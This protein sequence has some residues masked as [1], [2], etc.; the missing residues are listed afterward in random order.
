MRTSISGY[1]RIGKARELKF[2]TEAWLKGT[3]TEEGL[4]EVAREIRRESWKRIREA[5]IDLV[6]SNDFSL[7]DTTL[8]AAF[9]IGAIPERFA[10]A[11]LSPLERYF[12]MARGFQDTAR[13]ID[14]KALPMRKWFTTNYHYIV[15]EL[16]DESELIPSA[17]RIIS[18][19]NEARAL[20][21]D[22]R[23]TIIGPF[24]FLYL[25]SVSGARSRQDFSTEIADAYAK[26]L[27]LAGKEGIRAVEFDES[28]L[29]TDVSE[30]DLAAFSAIYDRIFAQKPGIDVILRSSFGDIRDAWDEVMA[31]PFSGIGLDFVDGKEGNLALLSERG[32]PTDRDLYAGIINGKNVWKLDDDY[33]RGLLGNIAH[34]AGIGPD[35]ERLIVAPSCS[36]LHVP[37]SASREDGL[38]PEVRARLSFAEEKCDE[39]I[40]L[41]KTYSESATSTGRAD[42][43]IINADNTIIRAGGGKGCTDDTHHR[44]LTVEQR[45]PSR[46]ER[47][48]VQR[49]AFSLPPLPT[50]TIG[51]FPQT[52]EVTSLR[53]KLRKG[54][55]ARSFYDAE[56]KRMVARAI[57]LQEEAGIDVLVHGEFERNDMVEFFGQSL[58]GFAFTAHGWVQS[59]GTRCVKPPIIVGDVRRSKPITVDLAAYAQSLTDKPVKGM[60]TGPV[61]ILNWSFPREDIPLSESA[62][63]IALAIREEVLD[64]EKAGIG[65]IQIDEAALKE[66]LPLRAKDRGPLYLDWAIPAFRLCSNGVRPETQIHTHMCYSDFS[67]ILPEIDA[68]DADVITFEAARSQSSILEALRTSGFETDVGPGVYDIHSPRIPSVDE[69]ERVIRKMVG[70]LGR[71]RER[72]D[73]LWVNPD[74]GLKTRGESETWQALGNMVTAAKRVRE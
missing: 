45:T 39:L 19:W 68:L 37:L 62:R 27:F 64:L 70:A 22:A 58:E 56:I 54:E 10:A 11:S 29:V 46:L 53:S 50:T 59:Y 18:E 21:I 13:G 28:F 4:L 44:P 42:D 66:K 73:G 25:A 23:P 7:Y 43:P 2:A 26:V 30:R 61:T 32:F 51:S 48:A 71:T 52:A 63:Q 17:D 60:L 1:P 24:T 49:T 9:M 5:G 57:T 67:D 36:L 72:Y 35:G 38:A 69:L 74:C 31:Q 16:S 12:A 47:K 65:I 15:P 41:T 8:D 6:P 34:L 3:I 20:G 14:L 33:A 40:Q 55:I